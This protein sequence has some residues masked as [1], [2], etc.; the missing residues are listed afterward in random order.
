VAQEELLKLNDW[1]GKLWGDVFPDSDEQWKTVIVPGEREAKNTWRLRPPPEPS[2]TATLDVEIDGRGLTV[3]V[4]SLDDDAFEAVEVTSERNRLEE[5]LALPPGRYR[6]ELTDWLFSWMEYKGGAYQYVHPVT[7]EVTLGGGESSRQSFTRDLS[8]LLTFERTV[9]SAPAMFNWP[10]PA[11]SGD[12]PVSGHQVDRRQE[13]CIKVLLKAFLDGKPELTEAEI[14]AGAGIEDATF[15]EIFEDPR[16]G[17]SALLLPS[18]DGTA[19]QLTPPP[20]DWKLN[21]RTAVEKGDDIPQLRGEKSGTPK[22]SDAP[23]E[24][25]GES[26]SSSPDDSLGFMNG[27]RPSPIRPTQASIPSVI[28]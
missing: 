6:L 3:T 4:D 7:V 19:W 20:A 11:R 24:E 22:S 5:S 21:L 27:N 16:A 2:L 17:W 12:F 26:E 10:D 28:G 14:L 1:E 13:Q 25:T 23:T 15:K 8:R 18:D 9:F